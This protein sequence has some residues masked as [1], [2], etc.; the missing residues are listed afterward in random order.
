MKIKKTTTHRPILIVLAVL[1]IAGVLIGGAA[2]FYNHSRQPSPVGATPEQKR[3]QQETETEQKQNFVENKNGVTNA[4]PAPTPTDSSQIS[5]AATQQSDSVVVTTQLAGFA[6]GTCQLV[7]TNGAKS[8][9][10]DATIL[11]QPEFSSCTGFSVPIS[12]L[13]AGQW[14]LT[15]RAT[16]SGGETLTKTITSTVK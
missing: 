9:T 10:Q 12:S 8:V 16:P 4:S 7:V 15:L 2:Y 6:S 14:T 13:G 3:A 11:Y 5:L 1:F